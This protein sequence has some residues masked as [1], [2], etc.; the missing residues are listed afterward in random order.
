MVQGIDFRFMQNRQCTH[1]RTS[2]FKVT[3]TVIVVFGKTW[4]KAG[5]GNDRVWKAWKP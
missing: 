2:V 3:L 1:Q 4:L 5:H